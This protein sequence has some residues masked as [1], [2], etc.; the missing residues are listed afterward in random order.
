MEMHQGSYCKEK[1]GQ[2]SVHC[3]VNIPSL[4]AI[5]FSSQLLCTPVIWLM[6]WPH[7][8]SCP[9]RAISC[10]LIVRVNDMFSYLTFPSFSVLCHRPDHLSFQHLPL[11]LTQHGFDSLSISF[12]SSL[13]T[14]LLPL[15]GYLEEYRQILTSGLLP[16]FWILCS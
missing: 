12:P 13:F 2:D 7:C 11:V 10:L 1:E 5:P 15:V 8:M 4:Q 6:S 16:S 9:L 14:S 3:K